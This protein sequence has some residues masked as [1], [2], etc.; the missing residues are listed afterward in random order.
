MNNVMEVAEASQNLQQYGA[1]GE[2]ARIVQAI[3]LHLK[4]VDATLEEVKKQLA[5]KPKKQRK[6]RKKKDAAQLLID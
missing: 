5:V 4:R 3:V 1:I 6:Q 2:L